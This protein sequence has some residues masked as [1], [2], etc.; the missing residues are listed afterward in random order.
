VIAQWRPRVWEYS[1]SLCTPMASR[2][3]HVDVGLFEE[4]FGGLIGNKHVANG[5]GGGSKEL[6]HDC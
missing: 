1:G 4:A 2:A 3:A 5:M 6:V